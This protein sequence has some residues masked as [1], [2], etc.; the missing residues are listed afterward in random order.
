MK[1]S[2][3]V[4]YVNENNFNGK[5]LHSFKLAG[6]EGYFGTGESKTGVHKGASVSFEAKEGKPGS[7]TVDTKTLEVVEGDIAPTV[8]YAKKQGSVA[9]ASKAKSKDDFWENKEARD[10]GTQ[11][12]IQ[13]QSSRN[14]AIA[15]A[16]FL[17]KNGALVLDKVKQADKMDVLVGLVDHLTDKFQEQVKAS[18][19][20]RAV[21]PDT[22][23]QAIKIKAQEESQDDNWG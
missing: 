8:V 14:S 11:K 22:L 13:L 4:T 5:L 20:E 12:T 7:F 19:E 3:K 10:V 16:D 2:G 15:C 9:Y 18:K 21:E 6:T 17:V 1:F 23:N